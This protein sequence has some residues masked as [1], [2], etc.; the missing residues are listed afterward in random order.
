M[1][2][3]KTAATLGELSRSRR[4]KDEL[5]AV[6]LAVDRP[7]TID[8]TSKATLE[9]QPEYQLIVQCNE[10]LQ[11]IDR[12]IVATHRYVSDIYSTKFPE[13]ESLIPN[14]IDYIRTVQRIGNEMD[15]TLVNLNDILPSAL[16]M[17]VSVSASTTAGK[18]LVDVEMQQ[19]LLGCE[20]TLKLDQ[21]KTTIIRFI[22]SRMTCIAPNLSAMIGSD[23]TAQLVGLAG[24]LI[25]LS[26]I[27][28]CNVQVMGQEKKNLAGLSFMSATPHAGILNQCEIVR[29]RPPF[30]R[31]KALKI[32]A[33]KVS[34]AARIDSYQNTFDNTA[35]LRLLNEIMEKLDKQEEP[36]KARTKKA[37]P[38]PEEKK[39]AKRGGKRVRKM[40]ERFAVTELQKQQNRMAVTTD[41]G[42]YGDSAMGM[43][44]GMI[45]S[46]DTGR[47]RAPVRKESA[48]L[49]KAKK[50]VSA[51]SGA[52]SGLSSSLAFTP[53]QGLELVNPNAAA[54]RVREANNKW[55]N[56]QAGFVSAA[57]K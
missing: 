16:V 46:K 10:L 48:F 2:S 32:V 53:V 17:I 8:V 9:E 21:D 3:I 39:R 30:L 54:E 40:K 31:R 44:L 27:P 33:G 7:P 57:P 12:E 41:A 5:E 56:S 18:P 29:S 35:G 37:L 43:D 51:S 50:A 23:I 11:N 20:E 42:E 1:L 47:L 55:F 22:E 28:A 38:I 19:C 25:A 36:G 4:Y 49:K 52:T 6:R 34:L 15:I 45:G 13:L 14:L 24:G 26:R